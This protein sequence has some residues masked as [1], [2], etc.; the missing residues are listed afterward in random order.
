MELTQGFQM[1]PGC[2]FTCGTSDGQLPVIDTRREDTGAIRRTAIYLC[3][4]CVR[5]MAAKLVPVVDWIVV[6]CEAY[7]EWYDTK[8]KLVIAEARAETAEGILR[9]LKELI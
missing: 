3:A 1:A 2:C 4:P 8:T 5:A 6:S 9:S 7:A